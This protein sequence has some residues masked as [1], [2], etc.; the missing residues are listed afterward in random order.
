MGAAAEPSVG[1]AVLGLLAGLDVNAVVH[2]WG[3]A[4][5]LKAAG[6]SEG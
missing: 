6:C 2:H 1:A 4:A 5:A 3:Q